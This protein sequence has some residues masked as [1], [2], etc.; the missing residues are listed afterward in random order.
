[1]PEGV[2]FYRNVAADS[3]YAAVQS[4]PPAGNPLDACGAYV[5]ANLP[6]DVVSL[7]HVADVP[8]YPDYRGATAATV[9]ER[10]VRGAVLQRLRVEHHGGA[11]VRVLPHLPVPDLGVLQGAVGVELLGGPV[12]D[13]AVVGRGRLAGPAGTGR[14]RRRP[15]GRP[16]R[17]G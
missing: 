11:P 5:M 6:N 15:A 7:V 2:Q 1:V 14:L 8:N 10:P 13:D 12:D 16:V 9:N 17:C 3:P 4:A